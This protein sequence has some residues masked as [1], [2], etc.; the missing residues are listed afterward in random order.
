[1]AEPSTCVKT[2]P[3]V[4]KLM[5]DE[6]QPCTKPCMADILHIDNGSKAKENGL[7]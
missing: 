6:K 1:M 4:M 3:D 5:F 7:S 2:T